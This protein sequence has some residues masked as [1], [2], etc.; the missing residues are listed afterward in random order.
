MN[1]ALRCV[2]TTLLVVAL[3]LAASLALIAARAGHWLESPSQAP[4][5]ANAIASAWPSRIAASAASPVKP[6]A[7]IKTPFQSGRNSTIADGTFWWLTSARPAPEER[8]SMKCR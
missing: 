8:G 7:V 4:R 3:L 2:L 6:P 5:R 1:R